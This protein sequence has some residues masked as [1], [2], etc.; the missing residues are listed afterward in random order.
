MSL[1]SRKYSQVNFFDFFFFFFAV[2]EILIAQVLNVLNYSSDF[3][4]LSIFCLCSLSLAQ[5]WFQPSTRVF[6]SAITFCF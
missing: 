5:F 3:F 4:Y 1:H 2:S 6:V